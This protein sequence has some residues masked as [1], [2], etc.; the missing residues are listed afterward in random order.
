MDRLTL[1]LDSDVGHT[2][3]DPIDVPIHIL[4]V[5]VLVLVPLS[6]SSVPSSRLAAGGA[7]LPA[8]TSQLT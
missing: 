5:S 8:P 3:C 6:V 4:V 1:L 2:L 7:Q